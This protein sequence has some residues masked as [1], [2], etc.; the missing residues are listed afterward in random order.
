GGGV[1]ANLDRGGRFL[2]VGTRNLDVLLEQGDDDRAAREL[3]S[4][5][6]FLNFDGLMNR[7]NIDHSST[8]VQCEQAASPE[9]RSRVPARNLEVAQLDRLTR[10]QRRRRTSR[11][12]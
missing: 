3:K 11:S 8:R 4:H 9:T 10:S 12:L 5:S 1:D 6:H 7:K 2:V